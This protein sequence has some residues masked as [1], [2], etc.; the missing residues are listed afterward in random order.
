[1]KLI[2]VEYFEES[3]NCILPQWV[4]IKMNLDVLKMKEDELINLFGVSKTALYHWKN[5]KNIS[6]NKIAV[7]CELFGIT[8]DQY[9]ERDFNDDYGYDDMLGLSKYKNLSNCKQFTYNDLNYLF[10]KLEEFKHYVTFFALEYIPVN[11]N[12]NSTQNADKDFYRYYIDSDEVDYFC[13]TLDMN[14]TYDRKDGD[15]KK[16][17]SITYKELC[18]IAD[19]LRR[20]WG[21]DSYTHISATPSDKYKKVVMLSENTKFLE[22][23]ITKNNCK[24]ELLQLWCKLKNKN[25]SYDYNSLMAKM[26][27]T[28]GAML[29]N[30]HLTLDLCKKIFERDIKS[31]EVNNNGK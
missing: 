26:L 23:Y 6:I 14:V 17:K 29:D 15:T 12:E 10:N 11:R 28:S 2:P 25:A 20:D 21:D 31:V 22:E 30:A 19:E 18:E 4:F 16:L 5:G 7:L 13:K 9:Y 27:I 8:I 1:M 3:E 24:N